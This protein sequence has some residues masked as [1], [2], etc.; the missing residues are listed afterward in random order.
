MYDPKNICF[1]FYFYFL[2]IHVSYCQ[3][4]DGKIKFSN[5]Y[6][7]FQECLDS[8]FVVT[9]LLEFLYAFELIINSVS[10][11]THNDFRKKKNFW[12]ILHF[13]QTLK[14]NAFETTQNNVKLLL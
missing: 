7:L 12:V 3:K 11:D 10:F 6:Y 2:D 1:N 14:P 4:S 5:F 8:T 13:L 9:L